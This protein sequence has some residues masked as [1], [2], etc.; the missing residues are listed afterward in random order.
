MPDIRILIADDHPVVRQGLRTAIEQHRDLQFPLR[1]QVLFH[2]GQKRFTSS[3][4]TAADKDG[5]AM[6]ILSAARKD[7]AVHQRLHLLRLHAAVTEELLHAGINRCH[8][9][10]RARLRIGIEL[11]EDGGFVHK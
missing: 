8:A 6:Q 2:L 4:I 5:R 10:K 7:A 3:H 11:D 9:I 1:Q